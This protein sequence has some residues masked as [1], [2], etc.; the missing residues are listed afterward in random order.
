MTKP[1]INRVASSGL[2]TI[3]L[4]NFFPEAEIVALDI[5]QFLFMEMVVKEKEF[6]QKIKDNDWSAYKGKIVLLVC[7]NDAIIP[8]W[9][10]ML[11]RL[12][13]DGIAKMVY[14]GD[15]PSFLRTYYHQTISKIN[16]E[17]YRDKKIVIKGCASDKV[18]NT[19]YVDI[20][21]HLLPVASSV[22]YGEACSAVPLYKKKK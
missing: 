17:Q 15:K 21:G 11:I 3:N 4:E 10:Y 19:A 1:L 18:P 22:M 14:L 16:R 13:L 7:T 6:R 12:S 8:V 5:K 20:I 9:A 2:I